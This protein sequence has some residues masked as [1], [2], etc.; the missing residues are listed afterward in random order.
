MFHWIYS[1]KLQLTL[2]SWYSCRWCFSYPLCSWYTSL[3]ITAMFQVTVIAYIVLLVAL[4]TCGIPLLL[5]L[6][7]CKVGSLCLP[8]STQCPT[9]GT[10]CLAIVQ[11]ALVFVLLVTFQVHLCVL[12][13]QFV[14]NVYIPFWVC[15]PKSNDVS[16]IVS[17]LSLYPP[18]FCPSVSSSFPP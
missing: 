12:F 5:C 1:R 6:L 16:L 15:L 14:L 2:E 8:L 7:G 13:V 17:L 11:S 18:I 3:F 9:I 10:W 4:M